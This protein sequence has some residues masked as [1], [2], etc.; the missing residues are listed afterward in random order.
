MPAEK[1][2][3]D[4]VAGASTGALGG[5]A[6]GALS[7]GGDALLARRPAAHLPIAHAK[8]LR[9]RAPGRGPRATQISAPMP[10]AGRSANRRPDY[11]R[12]GRALWHMDAAVGLSAACTAHHRREIE[13][14]PRIGS[15]LDIVGPWSRAREKSGREPPWAFPAQSRTRKC[16]AYEFGRA[17]GWGAGRAPALPNHSQPCREPNPGRS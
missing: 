7:G 4:D 12:I 13:E 5:A 10:T 16:Q 11:E 9:Q 14:L 3:P 15:G 6:L 17:L 1:R 2:S 8:Q